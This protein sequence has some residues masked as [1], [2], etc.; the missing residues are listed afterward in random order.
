MKRKVLLSLLLITSLFVLAG[1]GNVNNV[2]I[3]D[4]KEKKQAI[5]NTKNKL[6]INGYDLTLNE[7]NYFS[8]IK[9]KYPHD[10]IIS[11]PITSLVM[12]Y[13]KPGS[14]ESVVRVVMGDMYGTNIDNSMEGFTKEGTKSINGIEWSIYT[15]DG[16]RSYGFNINYSNIVIGFIYNDPDMSKFEEEFMKNVTLNEEENK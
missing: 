2:K 1:C 7:D 9:F 6:L 16:R 5:E 4:N 11:N 14:D 15:R 8:K 3:D 13:K 10:A 12:D